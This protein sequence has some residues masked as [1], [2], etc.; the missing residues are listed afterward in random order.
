M[1]FGL[2]R[3]RPAD[4]RRLY[5][6]LAAA[7]REPALYRDFG[8]PDTLDGR[9]E[10]LMLITG[11]AVD[12]LTREK[13]EPKAGR[14]MA[15]EV[16][17]AF[18]DDMDRTLREIGVSD[19]G[20][21]KKVRKLARGFYGRMTAYVAAIA[22]GEDSVGRALRR[23]FLAEGAEVPGEFARL[24]PA[25]VRYGAHLR[26]LDLASLAAGRSGTIAGV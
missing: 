10:T 7:A 2:F 9:L 1:L 25:V 16:S 11:L 3:R 23:N 8:V 24:A 21:P 5:V 13:A 4:G 20:V 12:R 22:E 18:F 17:E 6:E 26:A 19:I 15:R 14:Q